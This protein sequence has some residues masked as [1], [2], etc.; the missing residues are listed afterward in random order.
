MTALFIRNS[1]IQ[2]RDEVDRPAVV[3]HVA[4]QF[5]QPRFAGANINPTQAV[6]SNLVMASPYKQFYNRFYAS[7]PNYGKVN[8]NKFSF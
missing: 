2:R 1:Q 5:H 8:A 7:R 3:H 4:Q 6:S